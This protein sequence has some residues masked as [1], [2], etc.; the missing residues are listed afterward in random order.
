MHS[1]SST[2]LISILVPVYNCE[3]YLDKCI[4]SIIN[5]DYPNLQIVLANDGS[6]DNSLKICERYA[7][8]DSRITVMTG[9]NKGVA[10]TRN[11]LLEQI[12]GEYFLFVDADDWIEPDMVSYLFTLIKEYNA[13]IAVCSN[14]KG[15]SKEAIS[16][17]VWNQ[18]QAIEKFLYHKELN[19]SL[20]IKLIKSNLIKCKKFNINIFY[21]EDALFIWYILQ[22][23]EK[24]VVSNK[25]LYNYRP[26]PTSLSRSFWTPDRKG[27]GHI[28]WETIVKDT[29][30]LWPEFMEIARARFGLEEMWSLYFASCAKYKYDDQIKL[31]QSTIKHLLPYIKKYKLDGKEKYIIAYLLSRFYSLGSLIHFIST[32]ILKRGI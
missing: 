31:R 10:N 26:N 11:D 5:Q 8:E 21:G 24:V 1:V 20:C 6:T 29:E 2:P 15:N 32:K 12:K 18:K 23:T 28:V 7:A 14:V 16:I 3:P 4:T 17:K 30:F 27:T 25:Q 22:E 19:G 13:D 9:S